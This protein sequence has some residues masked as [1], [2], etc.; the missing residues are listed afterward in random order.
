MQQAL[1][2]SHLDGEVGDRD[3]VG[4]GAGRG[5]VL[6]VLLDNDTI[7]CDAAELDI[8]VAEDGRSARVANRLAR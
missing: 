6:V 8:G 5:T 4:G 1:A 7:F 2:R 3:T